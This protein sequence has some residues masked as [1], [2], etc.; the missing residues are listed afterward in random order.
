MDLNGNHIP[1]LHFTFY[2]EK[3]DVNGIKTYGEKLIDGVIGNLG[4]GEV[5]VKP[6]PL[7]KYVLKIYD[8][9]SKVGDFWYYDNLQF[10]CGEDV[11][12]EKHIPSLKIILRDANYELIKNKAFSI[13]TQKHD[14]D[15]SPIKEKKDLVS[16]KLNTGEKG[17][18]KIYLAPDHFYDSE[19]RG[20][21]VLNVSRN[22]TVFNEYNIAVDPFNDQL[23][24]Y[25]FSALVVSYKNGI[26]QAVSNKDVL[27]YEPG[28]SAAGEYI[29]AK[30]LKTQK[31]DEGGV[32]SFEYPQG[33]YALAVKDDL[34]QNNVFWNIL[35]K[36]RT[37]T[38]KE[39]RANTVRVSVQDASGAFKKK[40]TAFS[41]FSM[42][43]NEDGTF[44]KNK[45]KKKFTI[46]ENNY[47]DIS[48]APGPY[49]LIHSANKKE[50][51]V[52]IYTEN[53]KKQDLVIGGTDP[54]LVTA[55]K[56]YKLNKPEPDRSLSQKLRGHILLQV[57]ERGEA[58][59]VEQNTD[60]RY[61]MKDGEVAYE[62]L[63]KFGLGITNE[64]LSKIPVGIDMRFE[65]YDYDGDGVFDKMEEALGTDM[66]SSDS[67][68]D[69]YSDST[70]L[71]NNFNPKGPG[72]LTIDESL[73]D[74]LR[75][76]IL[77]QVDSLGEAWYVNPQ[78]NR[79][80]YMPDGEAAYEIMRFLSLGITNENLELIEEGSLFD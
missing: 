25:I 2:E 71:L 11:L 66:Y 43:E 31:T 3:L 16:S 6:S 59:Y 45:S 73:T 56:K 63:R 4:S 34:G 69:G 30:N 40:G 54:F 74:R 75:G 61:Y 17:E 28:K 21:Y 44:S 80:Y 39:I 49:L 8:Q 41:V 55:A 19:K 35:I 33:R 48:L 20:T 1:G 68:S 78:D 24:E 9:N 57:E 53:G 46:G 65:T 15:G 37:K 5:N 7:K 52:A 79:R 36:N 29:L 23:L 18:Y 12:I 67:D 14:A 60:K 10:S 70:E 42:K 26:G 50:Y 13:Y 32:V 51:G 72:A 77:L 47:L 64:D 22:K 38:E 58:W 27:L 76:K 62:I